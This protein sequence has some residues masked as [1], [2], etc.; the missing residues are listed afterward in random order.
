MWF[1]VAVKSGGCAGL[2]HYEFR[3]SLQYLPQELVILFFPQLPVSERLL[4]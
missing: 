2:P 4:G 1:S 3:D